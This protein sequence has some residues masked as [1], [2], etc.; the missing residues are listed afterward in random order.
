MQGFSEAVFDNRAHRD[1]VGEQSFFF[2]N[3]QGA[4]RGYRDQRAA[5]ESGAVVAWL[6]YIGRNAS[7]QAG[8]N[9]HTGTETLGKRH[10][11]RRDACPLMRKPLAGATDSGLHF[12]DHEEPFFLRAKFAQLAQVISAR[13]N[14]A[15]FALQYFG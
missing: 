11:I 9:R 4:Q 14:D 12:V 8:T 3:F 1:G 10:H 13:L 6:E 5:A 15:T 2:H 7:R